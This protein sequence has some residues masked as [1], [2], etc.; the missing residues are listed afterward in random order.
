V[1][2]IPYRINRI[3]TASTIPSATPTAM[4]KI[5]SQPHISSGW[6][7]AIKSSNHAYSICKHAASV[8]KHSQVFSSSFYALGIGD[9][10]LRFIAFRAIVL[11]LSEVVPD[12]PVVA[13][14]YNDGLDIFGLMTG[15]VP[16]PECGLRAGNS[17]LSDGQ[18]RAD[19]VECV[20]YRP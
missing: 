18:A 9:G 5:W 20:S 4:R 1:L 15:L 8:L 11:F 12:E 19:G 13:H 2:R 7:L 16:C 17:M 14:P 3:T 10:A 6:C